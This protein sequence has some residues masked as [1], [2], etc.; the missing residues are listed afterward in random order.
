MPAEYPKPEEEE[1]EEEEEDEENVE[2]EEEDWNE[3]VP[4]E[5]IDEMEDGPSTH[6]IGGFSVCNRLDE[7]LNTIQYRQDRVLIFPG[8]YTQ[9]KEVV[10]E[11][12]RLCSTHIQSVPFS[13]G[14]RA[15]F[16]SPRNEKAVQK[17][18]KHVGP[19]FAYVASMAYNEEENKGNAVLTKENTSFSSQV[20]G[21]TV[22]PTQFDP[23]LFP[24][25]TA[26]IVFRYTYEKAARDADP[27]K[28]TV[29][30]EFVPEKDDEDGSGEEKEQAGNDD[31]EDESARPPVKRETVFL[32]GLCVT[33]GVVCEPLSRG[34]VSH[35]ILGNP[36]TTSDDPAV[37]PPTAVPTTLTAHPLCENVISRCLIYG[38][39]SHAV[40]AF[41]DST[42]VLRGSIV[43]G[44]VPSH[45]L[46][47]F[48]ES[49]RASRHLTTGIAFLE[50]RA[51]Q[52]QAAEQFLKT[53]PDGATGTDDLNKMANFVVPS[54]T[55]CQV[56]IYCDNSALTVKDCM[57]SNVKIAIL[58][59]DTCK[60]TVVSSCDVRCVE[61]VG[62]Y[63]HGVGGCA[64]VARTNFLASGRECVLVLG[65]TPQELQAHAA[66]AEK[67]KAA[68][69]DVEE[70]GKVVLS[71]HPTIS[72]C[73][74]RGKVRLQGDVRC[75]AISDN[76]IHVPKDAKHNVSD[77]FLH[78]L[79]Q[80]G[81]SPENV[82][83]AV[84]GFQ[85]TPV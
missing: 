55:F 20:Y 67:E 61:Q 12:S 42:M 5:E 47:R 32:E 29:L 68:E 27:V 83:W 10:L 2:E 57:V 79:S 73:T 4:L 1:E 26:K 22:T 64:S 70:G 51:R 80:E 13:T 77:V 16:P 15:G 50:H 82:S 36:C 9:E 37:Q 30:K 69:E 59:H 65:P 52:R 56:G 18:G 25:I 62:L 38:G 8:L 24:I 23:S 35:C 84:K 66:S 63:I 71:Q 44:A 17:D 6:F 81:A 28:Y 46:R 49:Q 39:S 75:G 31:E 45:V 76:L 78:A 11:E 3:L 43:D 21:K 60:G 54:E 74:I 53:N 85:I 72:R 41:P 19:W 7:V 58:L 34:S 40:Y 48:R 14:K 33:G